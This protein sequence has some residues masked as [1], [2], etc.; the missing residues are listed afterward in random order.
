MGSNADIY[1]SKK[2]KKSQIGP[3]Q[4]YRCKKAMKSDPLPGVETFMACVWGR[5]FLKI[6]PLYQ[7]AL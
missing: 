5:S 1:P 4:I 2:D 3:S 6:G 7:E